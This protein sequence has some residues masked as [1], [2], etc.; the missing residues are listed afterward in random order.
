MEVLF[1]DDDLEP[2]PPRAEPQKTPSARKRSPK[3]PKPEALEP[4]W[5]EAS[6]FGVEL[7]PHFGAAAPVPAAPRWEDGPR[8]DRPLVAPE[9]RSPAPRPTVKTPDDV[10]YAAPKPRRN[11]EGAFEEVDGEGRTIVRDEHTCR[12]PELL[13]ALRRKSRARKAPQPPQPDADVRVVE[14]EPVDPFADNPFADD[15][16]DEAAGRTAKPA[17]KRQTK[18]LAARAV[19]MLARR[20]YSEKELRAKLALKLETGETAADIDAA[21]VRLKELGFVSDERFAKSRARVRAS[22]S[23]DLAIRRE[24]R[25]L[26]L[27]REVVDR[28]MEEIEDAEDVRCARLWRRRFGE[29]PTDRKERE[30]QIRY[31]A[32]R[33][34]GMG[35]IMK[36]ICGEVEIPEEEPLFF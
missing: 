17:K 4:V 14:R 5:E 23:G 13:K 34:F 2:V 28:A 29:P 31:L 26:G 11:A 10:P 8:R 36:V 22:R 30:R 24:L 6:L 19:A 20:D 25:S 15:A 16:E 32:Y 27:E 12:D 3:S 1:D 21:V 18:S 9:R 7:E 35:V 33:G